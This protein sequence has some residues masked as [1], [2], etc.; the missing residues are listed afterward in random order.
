MLAHHVTSRNQGVDRASKDSR[1]WLLDSPR[2]VIQ[3]CESA[4][5]SFVQS[6]GEGIVPSNDDVLLGRGKR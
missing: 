5:Q 6:T 4:C 3:E 1:E 2:N